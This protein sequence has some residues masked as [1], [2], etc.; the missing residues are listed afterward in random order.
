MAVDTGHRQPRQ[1]RHN[2]LVPAPS[3]LRARP[4]RLVHPDVA[5]AGDRAARL[6]IFRRKTEETVF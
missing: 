5:A 6:G 2:G 4:R 1:Q 3:R